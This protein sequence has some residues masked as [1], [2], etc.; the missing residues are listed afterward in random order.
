MATPV[1][2]IPFLFDFVSP[3]SYLASTQIRA[4]AGRYGRD[5]EAV[6]VLLGPMLDTTG[7]RGWAEVPIKRQYMFRDVLRIARALGVPIEP[8]ATHPFNPLVALRATSCVAEMAERWRLVDALFRATWFEARRVDRE[9]IVARVAD[10]AGF[11]GRQ[12]V[13]RGSSAEAKATL[14]RATDQAIAAGAFGVPSVVVDGELF[15]GVDSLPYL[16]RCLGGEP[17]ADAGT[18]ERWQ[19]VAPS[20]SRTAANM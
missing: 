4:I 19:T 18:L 20:A 2:P 5:V 9:D 16:E 8:P 14:R 3:Y 10:E 15:W 17:A 6:P 1:A 11:D 12:L 7:C 13:E